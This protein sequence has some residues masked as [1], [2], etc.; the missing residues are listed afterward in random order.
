MVALY[1]NIHYSTVSMSQA[2]LCGVTSLGS[3][4]L[5]VSQAATKVSAQ[6]EGDSRNRSA[7]NLTQW[8]LVGFSS[9]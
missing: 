8:L 5:S 7:S 1:N 6:A 4:A 3:L 9:L 2:S